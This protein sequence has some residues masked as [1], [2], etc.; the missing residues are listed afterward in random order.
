M[1]K[2]TSLFLFIL[3]AVTSFSSSACRVV[4]IVTMAEDGAGA[5]AIS[6]TC[7][8]RVSGA[9]R[10]TFREVVQY[11]LADQDEDEILERCKLCENPVCQFRGGQCPITSGVGRAREMATCSCATPFGFISGRMICEN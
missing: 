1:K 7:N 2:V 10:C 11:A 8:R 4:E 5:D 3:I 9:P 6:E